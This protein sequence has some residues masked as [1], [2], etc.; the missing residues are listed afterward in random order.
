[1]F[2]LISYDVEND[3]LRARLAKV[4]EAHGHRVQYSVFECH[5]SRGAYRSLLETIEAFETQAQQAEEAFSVRSYRLCERCTDR[6]DVVGK[7]DVTTDPRYF[8]I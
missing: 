5:V 6:V 2:V 1:M 7:G 4:L 8:L 3:R